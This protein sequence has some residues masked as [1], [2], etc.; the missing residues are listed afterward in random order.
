MPHADLGVDQVN[1]PAPE[2][3]RGSWTTTLT[4]LIALLIIA[5]ISL[6][7]DSVNQKIIAR[8]EN[9]ALMV[10]VAGRQRMLSQRITRIADE[11]ADGSADQ[12]A[13]QAEIVALA[14]RMEA[15]QQ[16]LVSGDPGRG[17]LPAT[18]PALRA[19]YFGDPVHLEQ[20]VNTFL[21][22]ARSFAA[23]PAP[24]MKA[25][26][27]LALRRA[28]TAPLLDGLD[29]AVSEYQTASEQDIRHLRNLMSTLTGLMLAVLL[30][31]ALLIYRPLFNRLSE[32][33][34]LL[35]KAS[36]TDFLTGALNRRAFLAAAERGLSRA[37]RNHQPL[38]LLMAD[39][40]HF[41]RINDTYGHPIGDKMIRHFASCAAG[42]LRST[43][44][45]GR[46]GGEEFA[47]I[48]PGT[49]L[50]GGMLVAERI[51]ERFASTTGATARGEQ[52]VTATVSIGLIC[53]SGGSLEELLV[54]AD[55]LLY[56]AKNLGRNRVQAGVG[57]L[58][59]VPGW[60]KEGMRA[61]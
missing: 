13:G 16:K 8:Q 21:G 24:T 36:T 60:V 58:S 51:R 46:V 40:D 34:S 55:Q 52:P 7:A 38:C 32:T 1:G 37:R 53:A 3:P 54:Q 29:A 10:N 59:S 33:I 47:V 11:V 57:D 44:C 15:A 31:E 25:P 26:D 35:V 17:M 42:S 49:T 23:Q 14:Q 18:S 61:V 56:E 19:I 39:I 43:D 30:L 12:T 45:V 27:L 41:K 50:H 6:C 20:Q 22:H 5:A 4:Y 2:P 9:T 28:V 48:L